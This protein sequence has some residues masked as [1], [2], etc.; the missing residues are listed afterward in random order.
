MKK[1][2]FNDR[3]GLTEAVLNGNKTMTRRFFPQE[4]VPMIENGYKYAAI[5]EAHNKNR[6]YNIGETISIAQPYRVIL[7]FF[8]DNEYWQ[9]DYIRRVEDA[10]EKRLY[11]I[12]GLNNKM[13]VKSELML[14]QIE[15]TD[16]N[17]ERL[18]DI[19]DEDVYKEGFRKEAINNGWGNA[20]WHWEAM[21][22]YTDNLGRYKEIRSESPKEAFSFLIDKVSGNGT[23]ESN[24]WVLVY[25]FKLVI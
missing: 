24:P 3:F 7:D 2:M 15:I 25:S 13:F 1:I 12:K 18:Q 22:T 17:V 11:D 10:H 5:A 20:A 9:L 19:S 23:W 14:H 16:I 4:F 8:Q 21:L 6:C